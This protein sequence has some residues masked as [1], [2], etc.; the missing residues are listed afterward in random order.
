MRRK[1][2]ISPCKEI[3]TDQLFKRMH[4]RPANCKPPC[5]EDDTSLRYRKISSANTTSYSLQYFRHQLPKNTST[6]NSTKHADSGCLKISQLLRMRWESN[7]RSPSVK[8]PP[9]NHF[10]ILKLTNITTNIDR[11]RSFARSTASK[12]NY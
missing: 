5:S 11:S 12:E 3:N 7:S 1:S 9:Q 6:S 4:S 10:R 8:D 2:F